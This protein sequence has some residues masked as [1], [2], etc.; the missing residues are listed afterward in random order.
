MTTTLH[1]HTSVLDS[2][3]FKRLRHVRIELRES[4]PQQTEQEHAG[5][6]QTNDCPEARVRHAGAF[7][8]GQ[9][10]SIWTGLLPH[11]RL[12][13]ARVNVN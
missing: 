11:V 12:D 5:L 9:Q 6:Y 4:L 13:T 7:M 8:D 2:D 10:R 3:L 1:I